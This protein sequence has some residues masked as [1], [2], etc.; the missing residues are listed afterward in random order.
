MQAALPLPGTSPPRAERSDLRVSGLGFTLCDRRSAP[1]SPGARAGW[2]VGQFPGAGED[3]GLQIFAERWNGTQWQQAP[4]PVLSAGAPAHRSPRRAAPGPS[5]SPRRR[6]RPPRTRPSRCGPPAAGSP[7]PAGPAHRPPRTPGPPRRS[8]PGPRADSGTPATP[9][10]AG[11]DH[12]PAM[13]IRRA[14]VYFSPVSAIL[15][16]TCF[17]NALSSVTPCPSRRPCPAP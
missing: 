8:A 10:A 9:R 1:D 11:P 16:R 6:P 2:A 14:T 12:G 5:G 4:T 7:C 3:A 17:L 15:A 13:T